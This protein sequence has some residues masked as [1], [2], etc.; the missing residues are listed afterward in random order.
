MFPCAGKIYSAKL[1]S[2]FKFKYIIVFIGTIA[3]LEKFAAFYEYIKKFAY[4]HSLNIKPLNDTETDGK[5]II[6]AVCHKSW[7]K[8]Y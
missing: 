8:C 6:N 3:I 2:N 4:L 7:E 5:H 1:Q